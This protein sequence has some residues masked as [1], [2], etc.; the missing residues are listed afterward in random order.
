MSASLYLTA[1]AVL[2][3]SSHLQTT[4][5][6]LA[7]AACATDPDCHAF[8]V[9]GEIYQLHG[10]ANAL[11]PNNDWTVY[12]PSNGTA[13]V[14]RWTALSGHVNVDEGKCKV[15]PQ[16]NGRS[17][18]CSHSPA[19]PAPPPAPPGNFSYRAVGS[20]DVGTGE[21]S[22]FM[23][24]NTRY[25]LDNI[26]KGWIDHYGKWDPL[27][28]KHS[29]VHYGPPPPPYTPAHIHTYT[30]ASALFLSLCLVV[31]GCCHCCVRCA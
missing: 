17:G 10:C 9:Y 26:F 18:Q 31:L 19:P 13:Q 20:V 24:N 1:S 5:C 15:H 25:L 30:R 16:G 21:S 3:A 28:E 22:I 7:E 12:V 14:V 6:P 8:A 4:P 27:F 11:V 29:Y 2:S 23:F